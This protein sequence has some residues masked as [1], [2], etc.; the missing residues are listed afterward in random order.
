MPLVNVMQ[1]APN[2]ASIIYQFLQKTIVGT[3]LN[4]RY[5]VKNGLIF[6]GGLCKLEFYHGPEL[7]MCF[8]LANTYVCPL[9]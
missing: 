6:G 9:F 7:F 3:E 8:H 5:V 2:H 4:D 1:K